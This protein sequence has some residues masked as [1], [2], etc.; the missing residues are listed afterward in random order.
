MAMVESFTFWLRFI[1]VLRVNPMLEK[2][3][4]MAIDDVLV[5]CAKLCG[6]YIDVRLFFS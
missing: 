2:V 1:V 3:F 5:V 6:L 4:V